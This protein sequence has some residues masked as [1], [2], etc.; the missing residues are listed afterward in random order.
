MRVS[1]AAVPAF[2]WGRRWTRGYLEY[3]SEG[4]CR[5]VLVQRPEVA[6]RVWDINDISISI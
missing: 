6:V 3:P 2:L 4:R 1:F 5:N